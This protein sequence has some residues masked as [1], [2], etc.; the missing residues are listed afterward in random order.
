M[1][2]DGDRVVGV[3]VLLGVHDGVE[4]PLMVRRPDGETPLL[5][6]DPDEAEALAAMAS[7]VARQHQRQVVFARFGHRED[8]GSFEP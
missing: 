4:Q 5:T 3:W 2:R 6:T 7:E 8:L 1:P